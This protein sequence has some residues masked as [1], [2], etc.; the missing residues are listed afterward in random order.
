[1]TRIPRLLTLFALFTVPVALLAADQPKVHVDAA[2]PRGPRTFQEQTRTAVLRDYLRAWQRMGSALD[3]NRVGLLDPYFVGTARDKLAATIQQQSK[4]GVRTRYQDIAHDIRF[5]FY[6]PEGLSVQLTDRV[7]YDEQVLDQGK[8]VAAK[9]V[10]TSYV[11]IMTPAAAMWNVRV[12]Q[13]A[14]DSPN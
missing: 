12:F 11:V 5:V 10:Q 13:A 1:M 2:N 8:P 4:L 14:P 9:R 7:I 6:S 3:Q